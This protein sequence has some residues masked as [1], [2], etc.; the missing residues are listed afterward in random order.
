MC[1]SG[2]LACAVF[3]SSWV[4]LGFSVLCFSPSV[5]LPLFGT[6]CLSVFPLSVSVCVPSV[7]RYCGAAC[8]CDNVIAS[9]HSFH[10]SI[11]SFHSILPLFSLPQ[12]FYWDCLRKWYCSQ[13]YEQ[14]NSTLPMPGCLKDTALTNATARILCD[15]PGNAQ[16]SLTLS[17]SPLSLF[18]IFLH[19]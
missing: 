10:P 11:P 15:A 3:C 9:S 16:R 12:T 13:T 8:S 2:F 7:C 18:F 6:L 1:R 19:F 5:S 4:W 17:L 14:G